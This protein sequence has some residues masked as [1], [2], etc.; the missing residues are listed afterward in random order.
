MTTQ[1]QPH[2]DNS[3]E[4]RLIAYVIPHQ[5]HSPG[6]MDL[7]A[8]LNER[9]PEHMVPHQFVVL[10]SAARMPLT[11]NGKLDLREIQKLTEAAVAPSAQPDIQLPRNTLEK[12][13]AGIWREVLGSE[14]MGIDENFFEAGG[15]S[16]AIIQVHER[17]RNALNR[18][19][20]VTTL[21][22][23]P[24]IGSLAD[25]LGRAGKAETAAD[26]IQHRARQQIEARQKRNR[27]GTT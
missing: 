25:D 5:S 15:D 1:N 8:Y 24:T 9:L 19:I 22:R 17:L 10:Q 7:R 27:R 18:D 11:Q 12:T 21:F 16:V 20:P 13:I 23:F 14:A 4:K 2:G 26:A 6:T 3:G